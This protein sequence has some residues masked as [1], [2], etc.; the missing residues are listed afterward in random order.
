MA[1]PMRVAYEYGGFDPSS[2]IGG[3]SSGGGISWDDEYEESDLS[4]VLFKEL[5]LENEARFLEIN[6]LLSVEI[7]GFWLKVEKWL[8]ICGCCWGWFCWWELL[9]VDWGLIPVDPDEDVTFG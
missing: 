6:G 2:W 9:V 3:I 4:F 8:Y 5:L 7:E 1:I